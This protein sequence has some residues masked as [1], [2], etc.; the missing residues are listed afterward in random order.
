M[1]NKDDVI[2]I[3][4]QELVGLL[5]HWLWL[6]VLCGAVCGIAGLLICKLTITPMYESTT[7]IF[8]LNRN[9][10][11]TTVSYSD[12]QTSTQLTK[13]YT[14]LIKSRDVLE[15]VI[16]KC[17]LEQSYEGFASRV[18][19]ST[20][21]DTSL[22]AITVTDAD[23]AMAQL[24]AKEVRILASEHIKDVMDIEAANLET[25][26]NLPTRPSSPSAKRWTMI[27]GLLGVF[28]CA[29]ILVIQ[30]LL[31]DTIKS[32]EDVERYLGLSTLA[33]IPVVEQND[34]HKKKKSHSEHFDSEMVKAVDEEN[35]ANMDLVVQDLQVGS[36]SGDREGNK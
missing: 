29:A 11:S 17:G 21:G 10:N 33:M 6:L 35:N 14:P 25:E 15:R 1:Q 24:L 18:S 34:K 27:G 32:A 30:Y 7:R 4:L 19:V 16:E 12:L 23:P 3:D 13:N 31:D 9:N 8:I 2:E 28:V 36:H 22:I 5:I 26:A 20:V